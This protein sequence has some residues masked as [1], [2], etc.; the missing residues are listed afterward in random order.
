[1]GNS[2]STAEND[3]HMEDKDDN[4]GNSVPDKSKGKTRRSLRQMK[5]ENSLFRV[6]SVVFRKKPDS[7]EA[8]AKKASDYSHVHDAVMVNFSERGQSH[9]GV[10]NGVVGLRNLG[11][12]CFINSSLQCLSN[13]IP[14]TDYFLG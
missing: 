14:L 8:S 13:T 7:S 6:G 10:P 1:M 3:V 9:H 11:N 4:A 12:T 5:H 2:C